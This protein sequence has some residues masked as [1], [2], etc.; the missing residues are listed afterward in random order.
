MVSLYRVAESYHTSAEA[1]T[2]R[3]LYRFTFTCG[4]LAL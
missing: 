1:I 2:I 4:L 3:H